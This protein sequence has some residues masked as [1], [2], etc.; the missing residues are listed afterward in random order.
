MFGLPLE[1]CL[2]IRAY[3][4]QF[5]NIKSMFEGSNSVWTDVWVSTKLILL[6]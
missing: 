5:A 2:R 6:T 1:V 4:V 3:F